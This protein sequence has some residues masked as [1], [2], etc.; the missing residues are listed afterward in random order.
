MKANTHLSQ[1][2]SRGGFT[3]VE[4]LVVISMIAALA[5]ISFPVYRGIQK[6][7]EKQ[8]VV[9]TMNAIEQ[10]VDNFG[11]EYNYL[12]YATAAYPSGGQLL[13]GEGVWLWVPNYGGELEDILGLLMG[14]GNNTVNFKKIKFL[15][16]EEAEGS[17]P[18]AAPGPAG[19]RNG[20][21]INEAAG[22]ATL[23]NSFGM[24]YAVRVD[25]DLDGT[26]E[27]PF[28]A[29][30][31]IPGKK[32]LFYSPLKTVWAAPFDD[33]SWITNGWMDW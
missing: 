18:H 7:V 20:V 14:L 16:L 33:G 27:N 29:S 31:Q 22:T 24:H 1:N 9:M 23:Y 25:Y 12:P 26:I 2:K 21:V 5:G 17:G 3:L 10:A 8:K 11:T 13:S 19:Y 6:K 32:L 15:E 28:D 4:M 30:E